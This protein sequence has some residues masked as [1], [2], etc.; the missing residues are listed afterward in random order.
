HAR[1]ALL[2]HR[3]GTWDRRALLD[4]GWLDAMRRPCPVNPQYGLLWWLNT[5]R[6]QF[7][8]APESCYAA[9]GAGSNVI[10]IAP[11]HDLVA[12]VRWIDKAS[13]DGFVKRMLESVT[14]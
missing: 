2:V 13:L 12:V 6:A 10:F 5:G 1:F 11:D 9:R 3:R 8:S 7:P 14:G 4:A